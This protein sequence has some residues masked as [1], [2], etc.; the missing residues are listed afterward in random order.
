MDEQR[1]KSD[2]D[3]ETGETKQGEDRTHMDEESSENY[4]E[5]QEEATLTD[6]LYI[7]E[8]SLPKG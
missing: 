2:T 7:I 8:R 1:V 6:N 4:E 5:L 3:E